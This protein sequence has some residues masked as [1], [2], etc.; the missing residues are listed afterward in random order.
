MQLF[1]ITF[2]LGDFKSGIYLFN[3][4][5]KI[6]F[7]NERLFPVIRSEYFASIAVEVISNAE[8]RFL[9]ISVHFQISYLENEVGE[10]HLFLHF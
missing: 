9:K 8:D 2:T 10:P 1:K 4:S 7:G 6:N 5:A 3:R